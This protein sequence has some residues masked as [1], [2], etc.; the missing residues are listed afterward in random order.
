MNFKIEK[1]NK[2]NIGFGNVLESL[3]KV[4]GVE[5]VNKFLNLTDDV[6]E[7]INNY[8]NIE[9]ASHILL[10]HLKS[11]SKI[12]IIVDNDGD[13]F[14]SAALLYNYIK[15]I[16]PSIKLEYLIH[17]NK[18]HGLTEEMMENIISRNYNLLFIPDAGSGNIQQHKILKEK[19]AM[20]IIVLDHHQCNRY[21]PYAYVVNNQMSKNVRN[22]S[23]TGVGVT[24][25]FCKYIDNILNLNIAD[26]FLD[27]LA[28][29]MVSDSAD[30]R[31]FESRYLVL[32]GLNRIQDGV[33]SNELLKKLYKSKSYSMNNKCTI[34][35][36]AFYMCPAINCII[37]GGDLEIKTILFK[38]F[39]G[40]DEIFKD[41]IR[42]KGEVELSVED[43]ILRVYTKLKKVQDKAA[44][45][46]V[47]LM[48]NQINQFNLNNSEIIIVN[49]TEIE[50]K[51][52]NRLI[53]NKL[54]SA[55]N[56]HILLLSETG[57]SL[58]GS[59]TGAKNKE[60]SDFRKWCELT[61]LFNYCEG[62]PSAFGCQIPTYNINKLYELISTIPSSDVLVYNVDEIFT[63]KSLN[64]A[65]VSL[66]GSYDYIW[67]NKLDEP[68]FAI[69]DIIVDSN[70]IKLMGKNKN[71]IKIIHNGIE[72]IKFK[73]SEDEYNNIMKNKHN[74]FTIV[75]KFKVNEYCGNTTPQVLIEDYKYK[76]TEVKPKFIF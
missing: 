30:L 52:Y 32:E 21:S 33:N 3:L 15:R 54:C 56:K 57:S 10:E 19:L 70:N 55:Y 23:I 24:Y 49:G 48:K 28:Y 11:D 66:I 59:G 6:I 47:E 61:G 27:L 20:D 1:R 64:K 60:I 46:G 42:G 9:V 53:V 65:T 8:D 4:R 14:S 25:K 62:H 72:F 45:E 44:E 74:I 36:M 22:K 58:S 26:D 13:G 2:L 63:E 34:S 16:K 51:T 40:S 17:S 73:S 29:G 7:D 43:Y 5:D 75:G 71:T 50:N 37:R 68:I 31:E 41:K 12:A 76:A 18:A 67:G 39:I 38:A 69:E 35:G